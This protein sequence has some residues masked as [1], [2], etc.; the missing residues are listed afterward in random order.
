M[1]S[2]HHLSRRRFLA[3]A[4][5]LATA[6]WTPRLVS[7]EKCLPTPRQIMGPFYP[8]EWE[9]DIDM[10]LDQKDTSPATP[11]GERVVLQVLVKDLDC[12]PVAGAIVD[13]WQ[14]SS[15][16]RYDHPRDAAPGN[17]VDPGFQYRGRTQTPASGSFELRTIKPGSYPAA[18]GWDRPPHIHF[19][20]RAPGFREVTTQMYFEGEPLNDPDQILQSLTREGQENVVVPFERKP[21]R[22]PHL[23]GTFHLILSRNPDRK[24][25]PGQP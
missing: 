25:T 17:V 8:V 24:A 20:V 14:A 10:I 7:A 16:G 15:A 11:A 19:R 12:Q 18:E 4:G 5:S 6:L 1:S 23:A 21:G 9:G 2:R 13:V 3:G 22:L